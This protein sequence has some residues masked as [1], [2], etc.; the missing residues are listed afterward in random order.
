ME[1]LRGL[2]VKRGRHGKE[3]RGSSEEEGA[4]KEGT[5]EGTQMER[6]SE[7]GGLRGRG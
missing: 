1:K 6:A 3:A 4:Q 7:E 2:G 5:Q